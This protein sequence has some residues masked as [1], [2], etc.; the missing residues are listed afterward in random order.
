[1]SDTL[2]FLHQPNTIANLALGFECVKGFEFRLHHRAA[3][4]PDDCINGDGVAFKEVDAF[5]VVFHGCFP[6]HFRTHIIF[7]CFCGQIGWLHEGCHFESFAYRC[8][9]LG[10]D[11]CLVYV[12]V[13]HT[14]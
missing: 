8:Y 6:Y 10:I 7:V 5:H 11:E 1:M 4:A 12:L 13:Q 2:Y 14:D 3:L 9:V